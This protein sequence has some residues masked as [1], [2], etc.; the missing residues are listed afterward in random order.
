[1]V[2]LAG[3]A[4]VLDARRPSWGERRF[5]VAHDGQVLSPILSSINLFCGAGGGAT[6]EPPPP[7]PRRQRASSAVA[8]SRWAQAVIGARFGVGSVNSGGCWVD[9]GAP[10]APG[11]PRPASSMSSGVIPDELHR[12]LGGRA[13]LL[14]AR[15]SPRRA[16]RGTLPPDAVVALWVDP[17][18]HYE[19]LGGVSVITARCRGRGGLDG[20]A[21][22]GADR[23]VSPSG[24]DRRAGAARASRS[25]SSFAP[26]DL[27]PVAR[28]G[29]DR[30]EPVRPG[31]V[32]RTSPAMVGALTSSPM[33]PRRC[34]GRPRSSEVRSPTC[35]SPASP[36]RRVAAPRPR[37]GRNR[38]RWPASTARERVAW[39]GSS[40][41]RRAKTTPKGRWGPAPTTA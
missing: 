3:T 25:L 30:D 6:A 7:S 41:P 4:A 15:A 13:R 37:W 26:T 16:S 24:V 29:G 28:A 9:P 10:E 19:L 8:K 18:V 36:T 27:R 31:L 21:T 1:M 11:A 23:G 5:L 22:G 35:A 17:K 34:S 32:R 38:S 20:L 33:G 39:P 40:R 2:T 14:P 12:A